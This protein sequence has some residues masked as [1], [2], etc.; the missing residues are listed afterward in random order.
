[1]PALVVF[2]TPPDETP[3]YHVCLFS[4]CTA[5]EPT[6]PDAIAGPT[7]RRRKSSNVAWTNGSGLL[8]PV[9][10]GAGS[11]ALTA[12]VHSSVLARS[13]LFM[14][15]RDVTAGATRSAEASRCGVDV[16]D[17]RERNV[18]SARRR[19]IVR[20][21]VAQRLRRTKVVHDEWFQVVNLLESS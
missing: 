13:S 10:G 19:T 12:R 15:L 4:G 6:R 11:W 21:V 7:A 16:N 9:A 17:A 3:M 1:M 2:H 8:L 5:M 14:A 18:R 20:V